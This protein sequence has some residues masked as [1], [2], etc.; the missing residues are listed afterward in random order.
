MSHRG[1][2]NT[3]GENRL[4]SFRDY[5]RLPSENV[6]HKGKCGCGVETSSNITV[7]PPGHPENGWMCKSCQELRLRFEMERRR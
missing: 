1:Y 5:D 6:A 7:G 3:P 2:R 4:D